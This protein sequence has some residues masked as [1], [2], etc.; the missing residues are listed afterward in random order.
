[1]TIFST[2]DAPLQRGSGRRDRRDDPAPPRPLSV[3][4]RLKAL[5]M[6]PNLSRQWYAQVENC[7]RRRIPAS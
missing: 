5:G 7:Y 3:R 2:G 4:N 1:M 6:T